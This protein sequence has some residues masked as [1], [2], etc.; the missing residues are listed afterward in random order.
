MPLRFHDDLLPLLTDAGRVR[1]HP[2]NPNNGDTDTIVESMRVLGV[3]RPVYAQ[4][5]T[6]F[7]LAG[8]HTY[9]AMLELGAD[10]IPVVWLDVDDEAAK[11]IVA[12]DNRSAEKGRRDPGLLTDLLTSLPDLWGTGYTPDDLDRLLA[13]LTPPPLPDL[14]EPSLP[15]GTCGTCGQPLPG[16]SGG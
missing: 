10:R 1:P 12:V 3:Y 11:K 9:A 5:S 15:S 14:P 13:S 4:R 8:N 2:G 16:G 6:G 7:I